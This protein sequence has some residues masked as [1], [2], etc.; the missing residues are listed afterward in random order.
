MMQFSENPVGAIIWIAIVALVLSPVFVGGATVAAM[1][2]GWL[3]SPFAALICWM[4]AR[5]LGLDARRYAKVGALYS[6][7]FFL[8]WLYMTLRMFG[9][10]VAD[11]AVSAGYFVLYLIWF[12]GPIGISFLACVGSGSQVFN[13]DPADPD[14][15][16]FDI[17][18][19]CSLLAFLCAN[20]V[21]MGL[22]A[23]D[24]ERKHRRLDAADREK[25]DFFPHRLYIMPFAHTL[26]SVA[27]TGGALLVVRVVRPD[28]W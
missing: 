7:L 25:S 8:P 4:R 14:P 13:S 20:L 28:W 17:F 6:A 27:V 23:W 22:S 18:L 26:A 24:L 11:S 19:F 3:W 16:A 10:T 1:L 12:L 2:L 5:S 15:T 9:K 21:A